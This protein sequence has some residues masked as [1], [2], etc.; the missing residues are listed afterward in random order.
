MI[1]WE[2]RQGQSIS[3]DLI[4]QF[5]L[6]PIQA[7]L[8]S[9]RG[10]TTEAAIDFWLNGTENDLADPFLMHDMDKA[11]DR[12]NEAIDQ[13]EKITI[14]GDYDADGI[15]A[16]AIMVDTLSILGADAHYFIPDRFKDGYGPNMDSYKKIVAD[17]TKLII[18]VD[19]GITGIDEV[20]YAKKMGVDTIVTDHHTIQE[21]EPDA[22][23][24]VHCNYPG[25][26]YPFDDYCGAG[27]AYT[28]CRALMDDPM[29]ELL[30]FAMIGTIGDMVKVNGE[31][32]IIVKRGLEQLNSTE[33]VGLQALIKQA[34]LNLGSIDETDIGFTIAPRLNA[35]GRLADAKLAVEL[36]LTDDEETAH[37]LAKQIE[38]LNTQRQELTK[39]VFDE[40]ITQITTMGY[41]K[42]KTLVL[43]DPNWHQGVLGLVA[44]KIVEKV[45]KPTLLLTKADNGEIVGSGRSKTGFNLFDALHPLAKTLLNKFG[46]HD[47]ACG[48][49]MP[50]QNISK[51]RQEFEK[52]YHLTT[53]VT[54]KHYDEV[55]DPQ[56]ITMDLY[57]EIKIVGPF[58]TGDPEPVF[59]INE[60]DI[61]NLTVMGQ[62]K[63][64]IRFQLNKLKVVGFNKSYLTQNLI[65]FVKKIFVKLSVNEWQN[66]KSIQAMLVDIS[67]GIPKLVIPTK[68]IDFRN[69]KH[70]LGFA[71][72][73]LLFDPIDKD[74]SL[75]KYDIDPNKVVFAEDYQDQNQII[76][77]LD[78]PHNIS[79]LKNLIEQNNFKQIYLRFSID[80]LPVN[81]IPSE[82]KFRDVLK[83]VYTHPGLKPKDYKLAAPYLDMNVETI[84]FIL[85]VFLE[86]NFVKMEDVQIV[87]EKNAQNQALINSRYYQA[88]K[89]QVDFV[90]NLRTMPS[91]KLLDYIKSLMH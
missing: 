52:S 87:P 54:I 61:T 10:I 37:K 38:D 28:I 9:L 56:N 70:L 32:H 30:D 40:A 6:S 31:G 11:I 68:V 63:E 21:Q 49:S 78:A 43:Y 81:K 86:L 42:N 12:I 80:N 27:V 39:K 88:V 65:P 50:E 85:R 73:Y 8:F 71:D 33:H 19:N 72:Q 44:N 46:G 57:Q 47:F 36:L 55:L 35:V 25:Q 2:K 15:T 67:F 60:P 3:Q 91:I 41:G 79:Q 4:D 5:Q 84:Y 62:T 76:T 69:E 7:K 24:I 13:G 83:Y 64:H 34:G 53:N 48:L 17:G 77:L 16:T 82:T 59:E 23:A 20:A 66:R 75:C 90:Q 14:Y 89:S 45:N 22:Y 26:K 74:I 1:K 58:G 51:L 29:P 18:T